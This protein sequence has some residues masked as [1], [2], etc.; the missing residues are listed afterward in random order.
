[1]FHSEIG[2]LMLLDA[3]YERARMPA[4]DSGESRPLQVMAAVFA[5]IGYRVRMR[6][7]TV[8]DLIERRFAQFAGLPYQS[9]AS[10]E[11]WEALWEIEG[12]PLTFRNDSSDRHPP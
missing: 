6:L 4:T 11:Q 12:M 5:A 10:R 7:C 9:P 1:M 2:E 8:S 3:P